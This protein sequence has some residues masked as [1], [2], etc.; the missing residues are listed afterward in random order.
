MLCL[1]SIN[2]APSFI[3]SFLTKS[4]WPAAVTNKSADSTPLIPVFLL[5][6]DTNA[7]SFLSKNAVGLPTK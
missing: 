5:Y 6:V 7:P 1:A 2:Q 4:G 3:F